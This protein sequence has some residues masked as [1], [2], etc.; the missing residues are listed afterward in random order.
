MGG[1]HLVLT[2]CPVFEVCFCVAF[3]RFCTFR[4]V[5]LHNFQV[6]FSSYLFATLTCAACS[7]HLLFFD[8]VLHNI[9]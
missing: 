4:E 2:F 5:D 1:M 3:K 6:K 9:C 8:F 7:I